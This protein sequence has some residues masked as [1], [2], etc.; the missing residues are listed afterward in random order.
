MI[1]LLAV[2]ALLAGLTACQGGFGVDAPS[3]TTAGA[4]TDTLGSGVAQASIG[5]MSAADE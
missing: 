4:A 5:V 3:S 2:I 1:K